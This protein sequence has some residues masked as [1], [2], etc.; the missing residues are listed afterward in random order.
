[1]ACH[2]VEGLIREILLTVGTAHP[3]PQPI[4]TLGNAFTEII[5]QSKGMEKVLQA[6]IATLGHGT[7]TKG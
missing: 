4:T 7:G 1:M 5:R 2:S 6:H 3:I